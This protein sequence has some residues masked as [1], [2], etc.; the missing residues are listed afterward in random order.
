MQEREKYKLGSPETFHY[1]NQSKCYKLDGVN[2]S[3]EYLATRRAMDIVG[4]G[5]AE[6]VPFPEMP[7]LSWVMEYPFIRVFLNNIMVFRNRYLKWL[8]Q[9]F[10]LVILNLLRGK[11]LILPL[12]RMISQSFISIQLLN[13]SSRITI[14]IYL[15]FFF[16]AFSW[17]YKELWQV[18]FNRCDA[19]SLEDALIKRVMV[20][21][22]EVITRTLDPEAALGSRDALAKTIYSRLFDWWEYM[23]LFFRY[24]FM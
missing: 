13:C 11:R 19:K 1:L 15:F 24:I 14:L 17:M 6:Q 7:L 23:N 9:F 8:L 4:I 18:E 10:I 5:E 20:T 21:P 16:F 3:E 22:E 2:D 12:S